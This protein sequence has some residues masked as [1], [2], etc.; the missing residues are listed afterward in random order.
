MRCAAA[1][2]LMRSDEGFSGATRSTYALRTLFASVFVLL[3]QK[4]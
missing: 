3:Y 1:G 2:L 4:S